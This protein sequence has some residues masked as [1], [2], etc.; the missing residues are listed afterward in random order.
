MEGDEPITTVDAAKRYFQSMGCSHFHMSREI[1]QRYSEYRGL[2][3]P[4][5]QE[6]EWAREE[7]LALFDGLR[8]EE[9]PRKD[10]WSIHS[11]VTTLVFDWRLHDQLEALFDVSLSIEG[12]IRSQRDRL[13]VAETIVGRQGISHRPGLIFGSHDSS[14]EDLA[15]RY[16][17]LADTL[18]DKPFSGLDDEDRRQRLL[19]SLEKTKNACNIAGAKQES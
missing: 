8:S 2:N 4:K 7:I 10:L 11:A 16:A 15:A 14:R 1:P 6:A 19:L 18:A 3:I 5:S 17:G 12:V 13:L 9:T